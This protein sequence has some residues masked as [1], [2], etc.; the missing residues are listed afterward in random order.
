M[1]LNLDVIGRKIGPV[2]KPYTWKDLVLYAMG[3][4][5]G[6]EDLEYCFEQKLKVIPSFSIASVFEFLAEV[7]IS[8]NANLSQ[9]FCTESRILFFITPFPLKGP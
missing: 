6:F 4:G 7:G 1:A 5:A 8:S 2:E 3:V 9:G